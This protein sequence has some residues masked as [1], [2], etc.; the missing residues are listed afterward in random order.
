M[1]GAGSV[2]GGVDRTELLLLESLQKQ[3]GAFP[4]SMEYQLWHILS[5]YRRDR[6]N[7]GEV[8]ASEFARKA[9]RCQVQQ[10]LQSQQGE[11]HHGPIFGN[12]VPKFVTNRPKHISFLQ[13]G[14]PAIIPSADTDGGGKK[15]GK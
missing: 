4:P 13:L 6:S 14:E 12:A 9:Y 1:G 15:N 2:P 7:I 10:Q 5:K 8:R 11:E 3:W